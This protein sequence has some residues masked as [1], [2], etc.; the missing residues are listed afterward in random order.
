LDY[1]DPETFRLFNQYIYSRKIIL[2][3]HTVCHRDDTESTDSPDHYKLC[4]KQDLTIVKLWNPAERFQI[5]DL[6]NHVVDNM[7]QVMHGCGLM[8]DECF[9][10]V[11]KNTKPGSALRKFIVDMVCWKPSKETYYDKHSKFPSEMLADIAK[12]FQKVASDNGQPKDENP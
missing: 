4:G 12:N 3:F 11:Y 7:M 6:P 10:F 5:N 9:D 2:P 1:V 8:N